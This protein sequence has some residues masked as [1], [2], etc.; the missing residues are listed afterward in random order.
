[1][2]IDEFKINIERHVNVCIKELAKDNSFFDPTIKRYELRPNKGYETILLCNSAVIRV[3]QSKNKETR[4]ELSKKYIDLFGLQNEVKY[5]TSEVY[6]GKLTFD[7][8]V[9]IQIIDNIKVVF[10]RCYTNESVESF[11]CC[12]RYNECSDE[13][14]CLHPDIK[15]AK[16]CHYKMH[17]ENG[18]IFYGKNRNIEHL[19]GSRNQKNPS[20]VKKLND[21]L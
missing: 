3:K 7:E 15:F 10:E 18:L 14:K 6:W 1:M 16:G 13:K 4:M 20:F 21:L 5:T 19:S 11:G 12:S 8:S 9:A 17:L 2:N